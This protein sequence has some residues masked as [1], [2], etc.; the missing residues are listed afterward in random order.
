[1]R[2]LP[3]DQRRGR[4][5]RAGLPPLDPPPPPFT[6][7]SLLLLSLLSPLLPFL[8][9]HLH[10]LLPIH[11]RTH[12]HRPTS[13][14]FLLST[15]T[16]PPRHPRK[17]PVTTSPRVDCVG[18]RVSSCVGT[19]A[20]FHVTRGTRACNNWKRTKAVAPSSNSRRANAATLLS[21][22][23][24]SLLKN[25]GAAPQVDDDGRRSTIAWHTRCVLRTAHRR[26]PTLTHQLHGH[27]EVTEENTPLHPPA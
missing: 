4:R 12:T 24:R 27:T 16:Q 20:A 22:I 26:V 13:P 3:L 25:R 17:T 11:H 2:A 10:L 8:S 7:S 23:P 19:T 1:M 15:H 18:S 5:G 9:P 14:F 6:P 21:T